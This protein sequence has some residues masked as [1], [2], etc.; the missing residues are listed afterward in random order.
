MGFGIYQSPVFA[1]D[2]LQLKQTLLAPTT[3]Q[4]FDPVALTVD[5][6]GR[7]WVLNGSA[8][9]LTVYT[10]SGEV[11]I[12]LLGR[13]GKGAGEFS[14]PQGLATDSEGSIYVADTG[15]DRIQVLAPDGK[16]RLMFG[17]HGSGPGQFRNPVAV[18]VSQDGVILVADAG[19][20]RV[21]LFSKTGIFLK[22]IDTG[23]EMEGVAVDASGRI[24]VTNAKLRQ[25]EQWSTAGQLFRS[26]SGAEPGMK[27]FS[28]PGALAM[29][30]QGL[31]YVADRGASQFREMDLNGH[32]LGAFGRAGSGEG[33]FKSLNALACWNDQLY[34]ADTDNHRVV[35][36]ALSRQNYPPAVTPT[37]TV[38]FQAALKNLWNVDA[39]RLALLSDGRLAAYS[40]K[41]GT[42]TLLDSDGKPSDTLPLKTKLGVRSDIALTVDAAGNYFIA[43]R[44]NNRIL[45][46]DAS[47]NRLA[48]IGKS[49]SMFKSGQGDLSA[50]QGLFVN[51]QGTIFV[52]DT[53][54]SRFQ[55]FNDQGLFLYAGGQKGKEL[56]QLKTPVSVAW[57]NDKIYIADVDNHKVVSFNASGRFLHEMGMIGGEALLE[58]RHLSVDREGYLY[59]LDAERGRIVVYDEQGVFVGGFGAPGLSKGFLNKPRSFVLS[60]DGRLY[61]AE[62]GRIQVFRV[63]VAPPAPTQLKAT[64]GEGYVELAWE[65]SKM[66]FPPKYVVYRA[67]PPAEPQKLKETV[68]T[69]FTD[70]SLLPETTYTYMVAAQSLQGATSVP[71]VP[72]RVMA[73]PSTSGP[74][75]EIVS[76]QFDDIFSA[77]YKYYSRVPFGKVV[78]RN[79]GP[80]PVQ[81][82]KIDFAIQG[83]MD[84][85][86]DT[87]IDE[88]R[89]R[90]E[91]EVPVLAT[92]NN[93]ILEVTETTPI[94]S[95]VKLTFYQ[96]G[97]ENTV[98]KNFPLKLYSRNSIRWDHKERFAAFVTPNDPP[99]IDVA[100]SLVLPYEDV[101]AVSPLPAPIKTAWALFAGLGTYGISYVPRPNNP[102]DRVS[103]DSSTVDS[104]QFARETVSRKSGDCSDVV[105]MFASAL[106]S[107][108][109]PSCA[110]DVPG[111]LF[112][113]FDTGESDLQVLGLPEPMVVSYAGTYWIPLEI[114]M[115]GSSFMEAWKHAA[116]EYRRLSAAGKVGVIDIHQAWQ[117]YEPATLAETAVVTKMPAHEAVETRFGK[118]WKALVDLRWQTRLAAAKQELEKNPAAGEP[119]LQMG[120]LAAEFRRFDEARA[121]LNKAR[122]DAATAAAAYNNL[123]NIAFLHKEYE[124]AESL[125]KEAAQR[126]PADAGIHLNLA[127]M[128]LK[129]GFAKKAS[130]AFS[131]AVKMDPSLKEKY[132][133]VSALAQ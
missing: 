38:R 130:D 120:I 43:D 49:A 63:V 101:H 44:G 132:G 54:N 47:G 19:N 37:P 6:Q 51:K 23:S 15:N 10:S 105:A 127:R 26:Y 22:A 75:L 97:Q 7:V 126:D 35:V 17:E 115:L 8:S 45:K 72:V 111:H 85:P 48:E 107:L 41:T 57:D 104:L 128:Y 86:S 25:I 33:Q 4:R 11:D 88:L 103:L 113:M 108:S 14:E 79:N 2:T 124:Q 60:D 12:P 121:Y 78:L 112:L 56:G 96:G 95:Q 129:Q 16:P 5:K 123:G 50:P 68:E 69:T 117:T 125:Y 29:S 62:E 122:S 30:A 91:K 74:R 98:V 67:L 77:Y 46:C 94:Q 110:L 131:K 119:Q 24:Y 118:D 34:I 1:Y 116:D 27:A 133:D 40:A 59:V 52:A 13:A 61:T 18:T 9:A 106:E 39:D 93:K 58:P 70:D 100:R 20:K 36:F 102:Y 73:K 99:V 28:K 55:A 90:Q 64:G 81:K 66:R 80:A 89:F 3:T 87:P 84:F 31:L 32:T 83:Y 109:V 92:F 21:Q 76:A 53:G 65:A 82:L 42:I 71:S 114:T